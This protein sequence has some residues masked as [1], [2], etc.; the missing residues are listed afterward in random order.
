MIISRTIQKP[1]FLS[2]LLVLSL[3]LN[4]AYSE[5]YEPDKEATS[6]ISA[7]NMPFENLNQGKFTSPKKEEV[8]ENKFIIIAKRVTKEKKLSSLPFECLHFELL[9]EL[10]EGKHMVDVRALH[11]EKCGGDPHISL[12]LFSIAIDKN[13]G[14]LWSDARSLLGQLE[15]LD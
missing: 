15:K 14:E 10:Y 11:S 5:T 7:H 2:V 13:S 12:R 6:E 3:Q 9:D 1:I 4:L 8:T